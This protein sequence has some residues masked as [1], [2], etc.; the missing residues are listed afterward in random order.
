MTIQRERLAYE[1]GYRVVADKVLN[2]KKQQLKGTITKEGF[3]QVGTTFGPIKAHRLV[4]YQK[5]GKTIFD[6]TLRVIHKDG[7]K[8]NNRYANI[9]LVKWEGARKVDLTGKRFGRLLVGQRQRENTTTYY[10]CKCD[11]GNEQ[12]VSHS[13][14]IS[15]QSQSCG[16]LQKDKLVERSSKNLPEVIASRLWSYYKRNA[17][18]RDIPFHLTKEDFFRL[19]YQPCLYC[20][21][22]GIKTETRWKRRKETNEEKT[23]LHNGIDRFD[24]RYGYTQTNS[25]SCCQKCNTGKGNMPF[26]EFK[27]WI[28]TLAEYIVQ[29]TDLPNPA[30]VDERC[31]ETRKSAVKGEKYNKCDVCGR[32][33]GRRKKYCSPECA[34]KAR[35]FADWGNIDLL[36]MRKTKSIDDIA[37]ELG[38]SYDLVC[39]HTSKQRKKGKN[40]DLFNR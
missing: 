21:R 29:L 33:K 26:D 15:K 5:Y 30:A 12:W 6:L 13:S 16:C 39:F 23:L 14:L 24:N 17:Q 2:P 7:N 32:S 10:L 19:I 4:G 1:T 28:L 34:D 38:V 22:I 11:C 8:L 3:L 37:K 27:E 40:S 36:E 18:M 31:D 9:K 20:R 25:V 35:S